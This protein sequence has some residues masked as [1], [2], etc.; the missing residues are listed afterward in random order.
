[1]HHQFPSFFEALYFANIRLPDQALS[2]W[3]QYLQSDDALF[4]QPAL[5]QYLEQQG[6]GNHP[7]ATESSDIIQDDNDFEQP[8]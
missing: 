6:V 2:L 7:P 8:S 4:A 1:M 5:D 3:Q